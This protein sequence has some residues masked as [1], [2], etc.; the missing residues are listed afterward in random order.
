[1]KNINQML[2][3]GQL[4]QAISFVET[5]LKEDPMNVDLKSALIE[6]LCINGS[7]ERA[8]KQLNLLVQKHPDFLVGAS[9]LRQLI[10]A[11][12]ARQ[13]FMSGQATPKLFSQTDTHSESLIKLRLALTDAQD[14]VTVCAENLESHRPQVSLVFDENT[15]EE[16]RDLDDTLGGFIE[17]FGTDGHYYLAQHSEIDYIHFKPVSSLV[18]TVW[19]RVELAIK[20]GPSG[21]AH[22]PMVYGGSETDAQ[23]LGRETDW[24]EVATNV[25]SGKGLKMWFV[26][27]NALALNQ[28]QKINTPAL[29]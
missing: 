5:E 10:R 4:Q 16:I 3:N 27:D 6:L 19:R 22:I 12:Q 11:E 18:E 24:E 28:I 29:Q 23:K 17:I 8:D 9:N 21:E 14:D 2:N 13:D 15:K 1:M 20:D 25:M 7:L 26:D